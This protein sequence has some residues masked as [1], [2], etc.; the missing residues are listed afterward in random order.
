MPECVCTGRGRSGGV[1]SRLSRMI[2][3]MRAAERSALM[4]RRGADAFDVKQD[5][6]GAVVMIR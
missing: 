5:V 1:A 6:V 3:L 4:K 2:G